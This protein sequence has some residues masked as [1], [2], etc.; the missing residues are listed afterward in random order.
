MDDDLRKILGEESTPAPSEVE[1]KVETKVENKEPTAEELAVKAKGEQLANLEKAIKEA[2]DNLR[3]TRKEAKDVKK[4]PLDEEEELPTINKEDPSA[5]AWM[6]E[7][8][9]NSAPLQAELEQAKSERRT[10]ALRQFLGEHPALAKDQEKLKSLMG[11]Y[12]KLRTASELTTEGILTDLDRAYAAEHS[13]ELISAARQSRIDNA[14]N[15]EAFSD[16]AV[17][18]GSTAYTTPKENKPRLTEDE[19][20]IIKGWE[21]A[22]APKV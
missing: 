11:T 6:K 2:Q 12:E 18:R 17:S 1:A 22:G 21:R 10:F 13:E 7:I 14:R 8:R 4:V 16:I 5:K 15:D 9:N 19:Q 20:D 3:K